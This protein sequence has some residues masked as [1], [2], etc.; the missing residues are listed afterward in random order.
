MVYLAAES[1]GAL[2]AA[3]MQFAGLPWRSELHDALLTDLLGPRPA[4]GERPAKLEAVLQR[5]REAL[6]AP[7]LNPDSPAVLIKALQRAGLMITST[8]SWDI[9][10]LKHPVVE[11]QVSHFMQVPLRTRV[12]LPHSPQASP[13]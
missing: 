7:D 6:D 3:E 1:A 8:R 11:P 2:V 10:K 5:V 4:S 13:S 9:K 12:K